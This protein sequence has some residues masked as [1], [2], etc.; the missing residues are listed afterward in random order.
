MIAENKPFEFL[1]IKHLGVIKNGIEDTKSP[2][3]KSWAS[4]F[5][6]YTF[7]EHNGATEVKVDMDVPPEFQDF[8]KNT[9]PKALA[10]LKEICET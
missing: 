1:S 9:W 3:S 4:V 8:M 7:T 5:E 6:N 2:E 10:R